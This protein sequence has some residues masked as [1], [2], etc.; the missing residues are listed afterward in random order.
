MKKKLWVAGALALAA[1]A[2]ATAIATLGSSGGALFADESYYSKYA[3]MHYA[4][5]EATKSEKGIREYWVNCKTHEVVY[6]APESSS[7]GEATAYDTSGFASND[8]RWI[9]NVALDAQEVI[10][11]ESTKA[12]DL[13]ADYAGATITS[14]K[15]GDIDLGNDASAL[16]VSLFASDHSDDGIKSVEIELNKDGKYSVLFFDATFVTAKITTADEFLTYIVPETGNKCGYFQLGSDIANVYQK[17]NAVKFEWSY[18]FTGTLDGLNNTLGGHSGTT[19]GIFSNLNG[20]TIKNLNITDARAMMYG[21]NALIAK[22]IASSTF[23]NVN[24][25][26]NDGSGSAEVANDRG[27]L[28]YGKFMGNSLTD[29][30]FDASGIKIGSLFGRGQNFTVPTL[31][32]CLVKASSLTEAMHSNHTGKTYQPSNVTLAEGEEALDGLTLEIA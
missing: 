31:K 5:K 19:N 27:Y 23:V 12:F 10:M 1:F 13:G 4:K 17:A 30:T 29:C 3:W 7:V 22:S 32:N 26:V 16:D 24:T 14:M 20:A 18:A 8:E 25:K 9:Y 6:V 28:A 11:S 15:A 21:S 2:S